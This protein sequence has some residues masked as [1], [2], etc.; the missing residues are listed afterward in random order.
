MRNSSCWPVMCSLCCTARPQCK[1]SLGNALVSQRI[2]AD[3]L[4]QALTCGHLRR[5]EPSVLGSLQT[6]PPSHPSP[7]AGV[8][9]SR[10]S[11][12]QRLR[13]LMTMR[14]LRCTASTSGAPARV[15]L[16]WRDGSWRAA[17]RAH[18]LGVVQVR[19]AHLGAGPSAW[20]P[21]KLAC[22][23]AGSQQPATS[24]LPLPLE[25]CTA[26]WTIALPGSR[27][28]VQR[29]LNQRRRRPGAVGSPTPPPFT[30]CPTHR[31][32]TERAG[33]AGGGG[34]SNRAGGCGAAA[35]GGGHGAGHCLAA[36][37]AGLQLVCARG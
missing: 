30:P 25:H 14:L 16:C 10:V 24:S 21:T 17:E 11:A 5:F 4:S 26:R 6:S 35:G 29:A 8:P 7:P 23:W 13:P 19:R 2:A 31:R 18:T 32:P 1:A 28:R 20:G 27:R 3:G 22:C 34:S 33:R 36:G 15:G 9:S 12:P 37:A